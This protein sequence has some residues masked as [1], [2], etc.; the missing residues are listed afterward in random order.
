MYSNLVPLEELKRHSAPYWLPFS[1]RDNG[2]PAINW[3]V[4]ADL[5]AGDVTTVL[6]L[7]AK[8]GVGGYAVAPLGR[9]A[10]AIGRHAIYVDAMRYH[11]AEDVLMLLLRGKEEPLWLN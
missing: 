9:R 5:E 3:M 10:R 2:I 11:R 1:G 8:A 6:D 4:I 7:L